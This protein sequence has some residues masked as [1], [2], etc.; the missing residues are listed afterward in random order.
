M[1]GK[2]RRAKIAE[3]LLRKSKRKMQDLQRSS[4]VKRPIR[5]P[6]Q[7]GG[8]EP[9]AFGQVRFWCTALLMPWSKR[10]EGGSRGVGF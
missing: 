3:G 5:M 8:W 1:S 9:R 6:I 2:R 7:L 10:P 4:K